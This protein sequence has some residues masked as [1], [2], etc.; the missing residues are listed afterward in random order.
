MEEVYGQKIAG[1]GQHT[2][3]F[4][5]G[6]PH[7]KIA[8][9]ILSAGSSLVN[10]YRVRE[11][12]SQQVVSQEWKCLT[13]LL[14]PFNNW[15]KMRRIDLTWTIRLLSWKILQLLKHYKAGHVLKA[16]GTYAPLL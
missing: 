6:I 13:N 10:A 9:R 7:G 15:E 14:N 12:L 11:W 16:P 2:W 4:A 3:L 8:D 1:T 5:D